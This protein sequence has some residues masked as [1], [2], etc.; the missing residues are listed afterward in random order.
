MPQLAAMENTV[1]TAQS[2]PPANPPVDSSQVVPQPVTATDST[3]VDNATNPQQ[4]NPQGPPQTVVGGQTAAGVDDEPIMVD[5]DYEAEKAAFL[6]ATPPGPVKSALESMASPADLAAQGIVIP[7]VTDPAPAST[8]PAP[9]AA[10]PVPVTATPPVPE[11]DL[12]P[13]DG[14]KPRFNNVRAKS[15]VDVQAL[16]AYK[17]AERSGTLGGKDMVQFMAD[18]ATKAS[19]AAPVVETPP[20]VVSP[21][22]SQSVPEIGT[23]AAVDA[24]LQRLRDERYKALE[25]FDFSKAAEIERQEDALRIQRE[26][27]RVSEVTQQQEMQQT[28]AEADSKAL[29]KAAQMFQDATDAKSPLVAKMTEIYQ[30]W[31][32]AGDSRVHAENRYLYAYIEAAEA[33]GIQPQAAGAPVSAPPANPSPS[34]QPSSTPAPVHRPPT[35]ALLASG[36][37]RDIPRAPVSD[38][39]DDYDAEKAAFLASRRA[40]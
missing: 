35:A 8:S 37:S 40:A 36:Q 18:F 3:S 25:L 5:A 4:A 33:L 1:E 7:G 26:D 6:A 13:A 32:Q 29:T 31:E 15:D 20:G 9:P 16:A 10:Q 30:S 27:I 12:T 19:P 17:A 11:D 21:P 34:V 28:M 39:L 2:N 22:S 23:V 24:E 38:K 14:K